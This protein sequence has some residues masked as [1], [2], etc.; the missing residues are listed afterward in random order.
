MRLRKPPPKRLGTDFP[1]TGLC[2]VREHTGDGSYVGRCEFATYANVCP[3]HGR[4]DMYAD[5][6]DREVSVCDRL[7]GDPELACLLGH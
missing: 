5:R 2:P 7:Y 4:L 1:L 6:D 3:R